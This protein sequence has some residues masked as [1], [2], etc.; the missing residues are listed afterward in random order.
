MA[1]KQRLAAVLLLSAGLASPAFADEASEKLVS[2]FLA[3]IDSSADWKASAA[4]VSSSGAST[5]VEGL[6]IAR[7][8]GPFTGTMARIE[9]ADFAA[10]GD[11]G[12]TLAN[13]T[14]SDTKLAGKDQWSLSI[15]AITAK[16]FAVPSLGAWTFDPQAPVASAAALYTVL[17]KT[18]FEEILIPT[19]ALAQSM[20]IPG[21]AQKVST[22]TSYTGF[23]MAGMRGG[24][25]AE[26]SIARMEQTSTGP[27][28]ATTL[29]EN[30]EAKDFDIGAFAKIAD[31]AAYVGGKGDGKWLKAGGNFTY[32]KITVSS[33]GKQ[34]FTMGPI[35]GSGLEVRQTPTPFAAVYDRL[36]AFGPNP[37]ES[38]MLALFE[39]DFTSL[40]GWFR[41]GSLSFKALRGTPP[42]GG[43]IS[44]DEIAIED[45][46]ADGIKRFAVTGF[47]AGAPD[48]KAEL[49]SFE[50]GDMAFPSFKSMLPIIKIEEAKKKG[51]PP[52]AALAAEAAESFLN[53]FPK[54]GRIS[55]RGLSIGIAGNEPLTLDTYE[56]TLKGR[57]ALLPEE[58]KA[59]LGKL[60]IPRGVLMATPESRELFEALGYNELAITG[61]GDGTYK[62]ETGDY[63]TSGTIAVADAGALKIAYAL[64]AMTPER[65]KQAFAVVIVAGDAEPNPFAMLQSL[66]PMTID[67]FMLRFEDA[68]LTKRL[69]AYAA[70]MQG[71]DEETMIANLGAMVQIGLSSLKNPEFT[72][73]AVTAINTF[74]KDPRSITLSVAP[75]KPVTV[76]ELMTLNPQDPGAAIKLLG[77]TLK[78]N[79]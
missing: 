72:A 60:V 20:T 71:M 13:F 65:L 66:G 52:T 6:T 51:T 59:S 35:A 39:K 45:V 8:D 76:Q 43:T 26:N 18:E 4:K 36:I 62:E 27:M 67:N 70:K 57:Y 68:S 53:L 42:D 74:L 38:K 25:L 5:I 3:R 49:K 46:S 75:A 24:I 17:A 58:T 11:G 34:I 55:A 56:A 7:E 54:I 21:E 44:L 40:V 30:L 16:G 22:A 29:F 12:L 79:E 23:R 48:F 14:A 19:A 33:G 9:L 61:G 50:L 64:G 28:A 15:P 78:A 32:G 37:P 41:I 69:I 47:A 10:R 77:V 2:D 73:S 63:A 1:L 31:P